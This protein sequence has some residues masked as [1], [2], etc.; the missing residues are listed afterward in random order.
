MYLSTL[1]LR[2]QASVGQGHDIVEDSA[3]ATAVLVAHP[4]DAVV[5]Q[6]APQL[7]PLRAQEQDYIHRGAALAAWPLY[8][9]VAGISRVSI[10]KV[11]GDL[12]AT[13]FADTHPDARGFVQQVATAEPWAVPHLVGRPIPAEAKDPELRALIL[14]LLL[15]PW[16]TF[17]TLL[18]PCR[19][20][21]DN[22]L[23]HRT[24]VSALNDF[25]SH[26]Q[27]QCTS[28]EE[29]PSPFTPAYWAHRF[30]ADTCL[31]RIFIAF[32]F[33]LQVR[34]ISCRMSTLCKVRKWTKIRVLFASTL[35]SSK[36][37]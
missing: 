6:S 24:W 31:S 35:G 21:A 17:E 22:H 12:L 28:P 20:R 26:L 7:V 33:P 1:I 36:V 25:I 10:Q 5:A 37:I 30:S 34:W 15:K 9:Y 29:R 27:N 16:T 2:A 13:P 8:F 18:L 4:E 23:G 14:L 3:S 32:C 19:P 11:R